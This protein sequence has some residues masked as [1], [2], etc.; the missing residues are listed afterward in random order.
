MLLLLLLLLWALLI[1]I[2]R[3]SAGDIM[4]NKIEMRSFPQ[5]KGTI[6]PFQ[7][8][9]DTVSKTETLLV[10]NSRLRQGT[11]TLDFQDEITRALCSSSEMQTLA[12]I[13]YLVL[14]LHQV[15]YINDPIKSSDEDYELGINISILWMAKLRLKVTCL[16]WYSWQVAVLAFQPKPAIKT[17]PFNHTLTFF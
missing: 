1:I 8:A 7:G 17:W 15:V 2:T 4:E 11:W 6:L 14:T 12:A 16:R 10:T 3:H 5:W 9:K 13:M